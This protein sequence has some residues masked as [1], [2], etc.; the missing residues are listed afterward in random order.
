MIIFTSRTSPFRLCFYFSFRH[1]GLL[2]KTTRNLPRVTTQ[3][4]RHWQRGM[5]IANAN[6]NAAMRCTKF[7][8]FFGKGPDCVADPFRTVPRRCSYNRPRKRK[9]AHRENL[10]GPSPSKSVK[11]SRNNRESP[12]KDKEGR[13]SPDRETPPFEPP[14]PV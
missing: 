11:K 2:Y 7:P 13:T 12:K 5:A 8:T 4:C 6:A 14:H 3:R 9:R 10:T 1:N